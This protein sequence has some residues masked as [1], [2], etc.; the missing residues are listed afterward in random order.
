MVD[1]RLWGLTNIL[2]VLILPAC[3]LV[4]SDQASYHN[5]AYLQNYL[6]ATSLSISGDRSC[7]LDA[8]QELY[9]WGD[10]SSGSFGP[11]AA[12]GEQVN[13]PRQLRMGGTHDQFLEVAQNRSNLCA[14]DLNGQ[15]ACRGDWGD[16]TILEP[17]P[18]SAVAKFSKISLGQDFGCGIGTTG[19]GVACFGRSATGRGIVSVLSTHAAN[20]LRFREGLDGEVRALLVFANGDVLV[21]GTFSH[22]SG[23]KTG[24][25]LKLRADGTLDGGFVFGRQ[26][27]GVVYALLNLDGGDVMVGGSFA[28]VA[29]SIPRSIARI[30]SSGEVNLDFYSHLPLGVGFGGGAGAVYTLVKNGVGN[31]VVGG[32]FDTLGANNVPPHLTRIKPDGSSDGTFNPGHSGGFMGDI[33]S[34]VYAV[35]IVDPGAGDGG[36]MVVGGS[37]A[38][39]QG[40]PLGSLVGLRADGSVNP[41]FYCGNPLISS[42]S[43]TI[44]SIKIQMKNNEAKLLVGGAFSNYG[45]SPVPQGIVRLSMT[46]NRDPNFE[47][48]LNSSGFNG[49]VSG[50]EVGADSSIFVVGDFDM[51]GGMVANSVVKLSPDGLRDS[52]FDASSATPIASIHAMALVIP[53]VNSGETNLLLGDYTP[54]SPVP[55][56]YHAGLVKLNSA[57]DPVANFGYTRRIVD[58]Q[59]AGN[60]ACALIAATRA[61]RASLESLHCW[62]I[63]GFAQL[64]I[65]PS[66]DSSLF[67]IVNP[68][69]A[70]TE[71]QDFRLYP[72]QLCYQR[73]GQCSWRCRG[74]NYS[75]DDTSFSSLAEQNRLMETASDST[76]MRPP[77]SADDFTLGKYQISAGLEFVFQT[78]LNREVFFDLPFGCRINA[79]DLQCQGYVS[80][81]PPETVV[82]ANFKNRRA[83][84]ASGNWQVFAHA[85]MVGKKSVKDFALGKNHGCLINAD[86][87][88]HC[89]G[90]AR[91]GQLGLGPM[92]TDTISV[93]MPLVI[94]K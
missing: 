44:R 79:G 71:V 41:N 4:P 33:T 16:G 38:R 86:N 80:S 91:N 25:L 40:L 93:P 10:N 46:G 72:S 42:K 12:Y 32:R 50:M 3:F 75:L 88:V 37:F 73:R 66:A 78:G 2:L 27:Q 17:I 22:Y 20:K 48:S 31:V 81:S 24:P 36:E 1:M 65:N 52:T 30:S 23:I 47:I 6:Q 11:T 68:Q 60:S 55:G 63:N 92:G 74:A 35:A 64:L 57:G 70:Q 39:Y 21:G 51:L 69:I 62:G 94:A 15:V 9:C 90:D 89:W 14:L 53:T 7:A 58:L 54:L 45:G 43:G 8:H 26:L 59:A 28:Q 84:R 56:I 61:G 83:L 18:D 77:L 67:K 19:N 85:Q 5:G 87:I 82:G 34:A 49:P 29:G 13:A 76:S